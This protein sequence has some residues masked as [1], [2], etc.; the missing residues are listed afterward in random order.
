MNNLK[1]MKKKELILAIL[2]G[3][4]ALFSFL[5]FTFHAFRLTDDTEQLLGLGGYGALGASTNINGFKMIQ[6]IGDFSG[7]YKFYAFIDVAALIGSIL[8]IGYFVYALLNKTA[9]EKL[10]IY[11]K[12]IAIAL[13]ISVFMLIHGIHL[14]E[15]MNDDFWY[16][17]ELSGTDPSIVKAL[18]DFGYKTEGFWP[19]ILIGALTA[20]YVFVIKKLPEDQ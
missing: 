17:I 1:E 3:A 5:A 15:K 19:L 10:A 20:A 18:G 16:G 12:V 7:I 8:A 4:I 13:V 14:T 9:E 11:K 6:H 2:V